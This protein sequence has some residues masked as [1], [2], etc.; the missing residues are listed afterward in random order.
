MAR[1]VL[2]FPGAR[3]VQILPGQT[4]IAG[5]GDSC[6]LDLTDYFKG[7]VISREHFKIF[8]K[9]HQF[10]ILDDSSTHGTAVNGFPL[11]KGQARVLQHED[12]IKVA[13]QAD[14]IIK[15][16]DP[17]KTPPLP[18]DPQLDF[19]LKPL[20]E[21]KDVYLLGV[22]GTG[23]TT[24]LNKLI[25]YDTPYATS[26]PAHGQALVFFYLNCRSVLSNL[27]LS[28]FFARLIA[29]TKLAFGG[30]WPEPLWESA[31]RLA[32]GNCALQEIQD[33]ILAAIRIT[34]ERLQKRVVFLLDQFDDVCYELP[35]DLFILLKDV[36]QLTDPQALLVLAMR[37]ALRNE[38]DDIDQFLRVMPPS[39][40]RWL[41]P[42]PAALLKQAMGARHLNEDQ[43]DQCLQLGGG[44]PRL[45]DLVATVLENTQAVAELADLLAAP[46]IAEHCHKM[47][48]GLAVAEQLALLSVAAGKAQMSLAAQTKLTQ[49][50][51]LVVKEADEL[52]FKS[53]LFGA[54]VKSL[55]QSL[56]G[57]TGLAIDGVNFWIDGQ[58]VAPEEL[59]ALERDL[60]KYLI[61]QDGKICTAARLSEKVWGTGASSEMIAQV[62]RRLRQKLDAR[63]PGAGKR[64]IVAVP[65]QGYRYAIETVKTT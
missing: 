49:A 33:A 43:L 18:V 24:T 23:K 21:N 37:D 11:V 54:F 22:A 8:Y 50:R 26:Q 62:V 20:R 46:N 28:N 45:T 57:Q 52:V 58:R 34:H 47:W 2:N 41:Q 56:P 14:G 55:L 40:N 25:Q 44:Q 30:H 35:S 42:P 3:K 64:Y 29:T 27:T 36:K 5:R 59:S 13:D 53:P 10:Y 51:W 15:V 31:E 9:D 16:T 39:G 4:L 32:A 17:E 1:L 48:E 7:S 61:E 6:T 38:N 63:S 65:G 19:V 12:E 60:L